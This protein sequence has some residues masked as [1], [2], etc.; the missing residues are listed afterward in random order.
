M[1]HRMPQSEKLS[2]VAGG[3][4]ESEPKITGKLILLHVLS[5]WVL[6]SALPLLLRRL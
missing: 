6:R 2:A 4:H 3:I 1:K 5:L